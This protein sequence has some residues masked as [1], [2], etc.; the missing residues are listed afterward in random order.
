MREQPCEQC[1]KPY[2]RN[3]LLS[4]F[5]RILCRPCGE[6]SLGQSDQEQINDQTVFPLSD[7]TICARC[8]ADGGDREYD[9]FLDL[10]ICPTC[11]HSM[12]HYR[13]P[14]WVKSFFAGI[15]IVT[16]F[17]IVWNARFFQAR[18]LMDQAIKKG[19][20]EGNLET[21]SEK[22]FKAASL[23]PESRDLNVLS[24][25]FG[26]ICDLRVDDSHSA[27]AHFKACK[28]LPEGYQVQLYTRAAESG[29][30]FDNKDYRRFLEL[31]L[32]TRDA[33]PDDP[34]SEG[35]VASAYACLYAEHGEEAY[36]QKALE[37]LGQAEEKAAAQDFKEFEE[38][39]DRILYRLETRRVISRNEYYQE[40]G[41]TPPEDLK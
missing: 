15:L 10:P 21:A 23:V 3:E 22:M 28:E 5:D 24:H 38:Y 34:T 2:G 8:G 19:F 31:S 26:G 39:R 33:F 29:V 16:L 41:K 37:H 11:N 36:K 9:L 30:A 20:V 7:P 13:Y 6:E 27:L 18:I 1:G 40:T 35:Q 25:Y 14:T 17:S 32:N 4:V 12:V